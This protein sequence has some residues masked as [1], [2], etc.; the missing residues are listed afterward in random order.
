[1][2]AASATP[3]ATDPTLL[4]DLADLLRRAGHAHHLAYLTAGGVDPDWAIWYAGYPRA[5]LGDRLGAVLSRSELVYRLLKAEQAHT[6][7]GAG[8]PWPEF[9]SPILVE[10]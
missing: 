4:A 1:M 8:T 2:T 6:A 7:S 10:G 9:Y 5:H 3:A